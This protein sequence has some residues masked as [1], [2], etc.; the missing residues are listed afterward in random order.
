M[1][2]YTDPKTD[3]EVAYNRAYRT[4]CIA[5]LPP[6]HF[7]LSWKPPVEDAPDYSN[8]GIDWLEINREFS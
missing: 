4:R 3:E 8:G 6:G 1:G 7:G 2:P 5:P